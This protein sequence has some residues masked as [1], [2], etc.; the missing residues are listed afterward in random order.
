VLS[1]IDK[2]SPWRDLKA[3]LSVEL[4]SFVDRIKDSIRATSSEI[5]K[6]QRNAARRTLAD[7]IPSP[8][9]ATD[10][11]IITAHRHGY[12]L[13]EIG[14]YLSLHYAT[15]SRRAKREKAMEEG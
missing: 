15:V 7:I 11:E 2:E 10:E 1:G 6:R 12:S 5:P 8:D 9:D 13:L 4:T 14:N 3:G